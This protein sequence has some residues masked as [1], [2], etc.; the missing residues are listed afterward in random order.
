[1]SWETW[2]CSHSHS[3]EHFLL[4]KFMGL[5]KCGGNGMYMLLIGAFSWS[6]MHLSLRENL[7]LHLN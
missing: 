3:Y 6:K 1:M 4:I 7:L 5:I 2:L